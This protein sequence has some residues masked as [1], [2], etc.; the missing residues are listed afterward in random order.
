MGAYMPIY[1]LGQPQEQTQEQS[2]EEIKKVIQE[3]R[4][5]EKKIKEERRIL[6]ERWERKKYE[7][8]I[9]RDFQASQ[10]PCEL[11]PG[12][13]PGLNYLAIQLLIDNRI[14][15]VDDLVAKFFALGRDEEKF[16]EYLI[17]IKIH[18]NNARDCAANM[19]TKLGGI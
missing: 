1:R 14:M 19:R 3:E 15:T 16:S 12:R 10:L 2:Q 11:L 9:A 6:E 5:R 17:D 4:I 13:I 8:Q 7:N 18:P